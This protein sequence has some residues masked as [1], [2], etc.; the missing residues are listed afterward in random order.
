MKIIKRYA[1]NAIISTTIDKYKHK[2]IAIDANLM[3]YKMVFAIRLNGYDIKN[4]D[5]IV[6]HLHALLLKIKGFI[7]YDITPIFVFDSIAP[8]IK[9]NTLKR[10]QIF[11]NVMQ[12][13]YYNAVTQ[14]EKKKYYFMKSD[15]TYQEIKDCTNLI[16]LFGYTIILA[17]EEADSQLAELVK[18][19]KVDYV[20]TDDMDILIFG[21]NKILKNFTI[22]SKKKIQEI[23]LD[24]FKKEANLT[25]DSL[26]DLAILLGCDYC[27]SIKGIGTIGAYK[28]IQ[29]YGDVKTILQKEDIKLSYDYN[30]AR[31]YFKNAPIIKSE[32]IKINK[33]KIDKSGLIEFL[34]QFGYENDYMNKLLT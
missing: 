19:N 18:N 25:Q 9:E 11:Q 2:T 20:V 3:I 32:N 24:I 27:P 12:L 10:R 14:D 15:I 33:L 34:K 22:A 21:G 28:L 4:G 31:E 30:P 7:K 26:V 17:P 5:I 6:T 8:N 29:K 23:D 13:K 16:K 1:P